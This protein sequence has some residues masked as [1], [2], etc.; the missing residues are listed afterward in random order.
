M[1]LRAT[2]RL[3]AVAR[4]RTILEAA[5]GL[6]AREGYAGM[7]TASVARMAGVAEPILYRHFSSKRVMLRALLDEVVTRMMA[8]FQELIQGEV[9]PIAALRKICL[10]YPLLSQRYREEFRIVNQTLVQVNDPT[11]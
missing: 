7:T 5:L 11:T 10:G 1:K 4:R 8:A 3:P 9:D 6:L 2:R